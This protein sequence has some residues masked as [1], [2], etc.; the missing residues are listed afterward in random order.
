[1]VA[2]VAGVAGVVGVAGVAVVVEFWQPPARVFAQPTQPSI[3]NV[4]LS[5]IGAEWTAMAQ[6]PLGS[7]VARAFQ[8][9][10]DIVIINAIDALD[11]TTGVAGRSF[12]QNF[13]A[14]LGI[15]EMVERPDGVTDVVGAMAGGP[16]AAAVFSTTRFAFAITLF[17]E[18][19]GL[20]DDL[21]VN[22]AARDGGLVTARPHDAGR[23]PGLI[24]RDA[25]AET[26][27]GSSELLDQRA[28]TC[29]ATGSGSPTLEFLAKHAT[30]LSATWFGANQ[31]FA[32]VDLTDMP[33]DL[34]AATGV[35]G[36][37]A[38]ATR[39]NLANNEDFGALADAQAWN[40]DGTPTQ[41]LL[42][43]RKGTI[44]VNIAVSTADDS[45]PALAA[46]LARLQF[47]RLPAGA[48][49]AFALPSARR[50]ATLSL[51]IVGAFGVFV[52]GLRRVRAGRIIRNAVSSDANRSVVDVSNQAR[53]LRK[54]GV[55]LGI[56][57]VGALSA[58]VLASAADIGFYRFVCGA[59]A[60]ALGYGATVLV[61]RAE[62]HALDVAPLELQRRPF[63]AWATVVGIAAAALLTAAAAV[64][65]WGLREAVFVPSLRHLRLSDS[66]AIEPRLL[67]WLMVMAGPLLGAIG[68][69]VARF[70]RAVSRLGWHR[71]AASQPEILYLRSFE[72][73]NIRLPSVLSARRPF[74]EFLGFRGR[75]PFEESIA[76][77]ISLRGQVIAIGR[78]GRSRA[79][80]GAAREEFSDETWREVIT[81]RMDG[82]LA[83]VLT[84]GISDGLQWELEQICQRGHVP[85]LVIIAPPVMP[86]DITDRLNF[87]A[88]SLDLPA[89]PQIEA[90]T[91]LAAVVVHDEQSLLVVAADR[92]DE[93]TYRAAVDAAFK[94][95]QAQR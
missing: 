53:R 44:I 55:R 66:L 83:I 27:L 51:L 50:S 94:E 65:T 40:L 70:A 71:A 93:S 88:R 49:S 87:V 24:L 26:D 73:D 3:D 54:L 32:I 17:G 34:F 30:G 47:E 7:G 84:I 38:D 42:I 31:R 5:D 8:R 16:A 41:T 29:D 43:F 67:A 2:A 28:L 79:S 62:R 59:F 10:S 4:I 6:D 64:L 36:V 37:V 18:I 85:K 9:G 75:D 91:F 63:S 60:L 19:D 46:K 14:R 80:L 23:L 76:W 90:T 11:C 95:L 56:T 13:V 72:D 77:E 15:G 92:R 25:P 78:P 22:Q 61:R 39:L 68:A 58:A 89:Q 74:V 52:L 33:Y 57:Q 82:A 12:Y 1:M 48:T 35:G 20:L 86:A 69:V 81:A 45:G 21:I